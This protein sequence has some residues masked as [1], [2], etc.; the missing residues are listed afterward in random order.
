MT[1]PFPFRLRPGGRSARP[2]IPPNQLAQKT[3]RCLAIAGL[4]H[5]R[6]QYLALPPDAWAEFDIL[7]SMARHARLARPGAQT[8]ALWLAGAAGLIR[9]AA[10]Q[11][12]AFCRDMPRSM[13]DREHTI[14]ASGPTPLQE[15][16]GPGFSAPDDATKHF[17]RNGPKKGPQITW[18]LT[19]GHILRSWKMVPQKGLEPPTPSLRMTCSTS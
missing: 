14:Q 5:H 13:A 18:P 12:G 16:I 8:L 4:R 2:A 10:I 19:C 9:E 7:V 17:A 1:S 3:Q 11:P 15:R 6:F